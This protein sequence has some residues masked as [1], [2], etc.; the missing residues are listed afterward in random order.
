MLRGWGTTEIAA[1]ATMTTGDDAMMGRATPGCGFTQPES[2]PSAATAAS[3]APRTERSGRRVS[4]SALE[5][6]E[7]PVREPEGHEEQHRDREHRVRPRG[8]ERD[9]ARLGF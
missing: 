1:G 5:P 3:A 7:R 6:E 8:Q 4:S 9:P 2:T